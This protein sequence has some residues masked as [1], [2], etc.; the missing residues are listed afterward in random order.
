MTL[1]S[2]SAGPSA[3]AGTSARTT[4]PKDTP[5]DGKSRNPVRPTPLESFRARR[6]HLDA[7]CPLGCRPPH[8]PSAELDLSLV[9]LAVRIWLAAGIT[10]ALIVWGVLA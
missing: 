3:A 4:S 8:D 1:H 2:T 5:A 6:V 9:P 7:D 10:A